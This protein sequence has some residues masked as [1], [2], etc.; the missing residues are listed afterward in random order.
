MQITI[1][2]IT[3]HN[4]KVSFKYLKSNSSDR[5]THEPKMHHNICRRKIIEPGPRMNKKGC[6]NSPPAGV[7]PQQRSF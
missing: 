7:S 5:N 1:N 3:K 2:P 4:M 6:L